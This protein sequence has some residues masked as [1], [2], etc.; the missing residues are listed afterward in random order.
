MTTLDHRRLAE[1]PPVSGQGLAVFQDFHPPVC[2]RVTVQRIVENLRV[3]EG[4]ER[5][6]QGRTPSQNVR[7]FERDKTPNGP[8]RV[9]N[10]D[11]RFF[12]GQCLEPC[13]RDLHWV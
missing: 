4:Q 9:R 8:R 10:S 2:D 6:D 3:L 12:V 1:P 11:R 5:K 13:P 7:D